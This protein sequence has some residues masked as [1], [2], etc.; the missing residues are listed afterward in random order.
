MNVSSQKFSLEVE[1]TTE[2]HSFLICN[3]F[4]GNALLGQVAERL[5]TGLQNLGQRF[6][7]A[8]DLDY[9]CK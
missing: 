7:S 3:G 9:V 2:Q 4:G 1:I 6:N 5:G 8:S